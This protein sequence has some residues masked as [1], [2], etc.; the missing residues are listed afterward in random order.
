M[1]DYVKKLQNDHAWF[2]PLW[3][4]QAMAPKHQILLTFGL[5]YMFS[6]LFLKH[7]IMMIYWI[8]AGLS[9]DT[10]ENPEKDLIKAIR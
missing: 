8:F 1:D 10:E 7:S 6:I 9:K 2:Y 3:T 4:F 5:F